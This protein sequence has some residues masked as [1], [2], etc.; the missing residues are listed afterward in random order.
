M[1]SSA[2]FWIKCCRSAKRLLFSQES[3]YELRGTRSQDISVAISSIDLLYTL[4]TSWLL[5]GLGVDSN[6]PGVQ[7]GLAIGEHEIG[8]CRNG[9][10]SN[11][12]ACTL[13]VALAA[14][15][16]VLKEKRTN[17][18]IQGKSGRTWFFQKLKQRRNFTPLST[19]AGKIKGGTGGKR[20]DSRIKMERWEEQF[21]GAHCCGGYKYKNWRQFWTETL[22]IYIKKKTDKSCP[23]NL[24]GKGEDMVADCSIVRFSTLW[25]SKASSFFGM[26]LAT[27][28]ANSYITEQSLTEPSST[29]KSRWFLQTRRYVLNTV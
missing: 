15:L 16:A 24:S 19:N 28:G 3:S 18:R 23:T 26:F 2:A 5:L 4:R 11:W 6:G 20:V 8:G 22:Y 27:G 17:L 10:V 21:N 1:Q 12:A 13:I 9:G 25:N 29:W 14:S 7:R